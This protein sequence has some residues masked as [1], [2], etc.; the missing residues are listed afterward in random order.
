MSAVAPLLRLVV[1]FF[2]F[3][4]LIRVAFS[5]LGPNPRNRLYEITYRITEPLL[6][7]VRSLMP[8]SM[9][10]DLS[11]MIVTFLLFMV[12]NLLDRVTA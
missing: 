6:A 7:P 3:A 10:I 12:L 11:P 8:Q 9:G 4:I 1:Y 5:W 2:F